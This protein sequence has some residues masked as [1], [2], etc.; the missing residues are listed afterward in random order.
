MKW[1]ELKDSI[2]E[3]LYSRN[4]K[5]PMIRIRALD[6][7]E[8]ILQQYYPQYI[9]CCDELKGVEKVEFKKLIADKKGKNLNAAE[10]SIINEIYYRIAPQDVKK[11]IS[12]Q[13]YKVSICPHCFVSLTIPENLW[14]CEQIHCPQCGNDFTNPIK[15]D[16]KLQQIEK[17]FVISG[18]L[19][20]IAKL[21]LYGALLILI[22]W[23]IFGC[24]NGTRSVKTNNIEQSGRADSLIRL[25]QAVHNDIIGVWE[26]DFNS[27]IIW[28]IQQVSINE[29]ILQIGSKNTVEWRDVDSLIMKNGIM[30]CIEDSNE[31][32]RIDQYNNLM[33]YDN[34]G[35]IGTYRKIQ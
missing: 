30:Y 1:Q 5:D 10:Q 20:D 28:R 4:L 26:D 3:D 22:L 6:K 32:Y 16:Q 33:V 23:A 25:V 31:Y 14:D 8:S 29:Y 15:E 34:L 2:I 21:I 18:M 35:Y 27:E 13:R 9:D 24:T 19:N 17:S 11:A 7:I 12:A